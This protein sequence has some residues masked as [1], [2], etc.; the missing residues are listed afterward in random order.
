MD[1]RAF[2]YFSSAAGALFA[3]GAAR[4]NPLTSGW[5]SFELTTSIQIPESAAHAQV[6]IPVPYAVDTPYQRR[7]K[8]HWTISHGGTARTVTDP[9]GQ[10]QMLA[11][12]WPQA[13]APRSLTVTS[14]VETRNWRVD[15]TRPASG[16]GHFEDAASLHRYLQPTKLLPTDGIVKHTADQITRNQRSVMGKAKAIYHWVVLNTCRTASTPGCGTGDVNYMLTANDLN[17]KCADINSLFVALARAAGIPAR[18]AYGLRV[19]DSQFG[20]R[21]LGKSGNVTTAQHCRAEFYDEHYGWVPVDPADVRKVMLEESPGDLPLTHPKVKA[22][23]AMLFGSW[24][25]NWVAY[26][27]GHDI[28]LPGSKHDPVPFLMYPSGETEHGRLD[29]LDPDAFSYRVT[30]R[31]VSI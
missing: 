17:G 10:I 25:M 7:V 14:H 26:N 27:H 11:A 18:D 9:S 15:L 28:A 22:A 31:Q 23:Q 21:S 19:A 24:E 30:S 13:G 20:Y 2:L 3:S 5:R 16:T 6:W 29:S 1:R 4:A 12:H 8:T